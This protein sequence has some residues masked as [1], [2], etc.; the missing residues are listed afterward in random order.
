MS[1][2][3]EVRPADSVADSRGKALLEE[4]HVSGVDSVRCIQTARGYILGGDRLDR[5][6]AQAAVVALLRDPVCEIASFTGDEPAPE[7]AHR[8][9]VLRKPGVMDPVAHTVLETLHHLGFEDI[10]WVRTFSRYFIHGLDADGSG[11]LARRVLANAVI[12]D[13]YVD[14]PDFPTDFA[15]PP[16][17]FERRE[18]ALRESSVAELLDI[19]GRN[20]LALDEAEMRTVQAHFRDLGRNP[21][22]VE[23]E[24]IAQ[25][26][27]EHCKHKTFRGVIDFDGEK[28]DNLLK[29]TIVRATTE[30]DRDWCVSVFHD[31]AG[32]IRFDDEH[33]VCFKVETHNHPSAIEPYGGAGTGIG[34]VIRDVLGTGLGARPIA[35]TDV[36]CVGPLDLE[37]DKVPRGALHPRR[38]LRGVVAGVR[39]YGNRMG[40]PTVS[41]AV[42]FGDRYI[43]NPLVF[44]GSVGILPRDKAFKAARTGDAIVVLG[45]RTGRDGIHGATFSSIELSSESE[46]VSSGAVQ[47]GDPITEK[48][49]LDALLIARDQDLYTSITDCG[50]GGLSSAVCEM[51]EELGAEVHLDRVPLKYAGLTYAEIWISEAQERM[52]VSVPPENVDRLLS[53]FRAEDVEATVIGT[54]TDDRRLHLFYR[55]ESVADLE[56]SFLHDGLPEF[57]RPARWTLPASSPAPR[58]PGRP[59][60]EHL[61]ALLARP[62]IASKEWIIRQYDHEVQAASVLKPLQGATHDGPGDAAVIAPVLGSTVGLAIGCGI[63]P[64]TGDLDPG[65]M[66]RLCIDEALRNVVAVGGDP[67]HTAILD[68]FAWG[69]PERPE[70][71]GALVLASRGCYEAAVAYGTPFIS[72]KDSLNNEFRTEDGES[73]SIPPTLLISALARVPDIRRCLSFELKEPGRH[74]LLIGKTQAAL[75]GSHIHASLGV[76][77]GSVPRVDLDLGPRILRRV[78]DVIRRGLAAACHDVSDGG[79]GVALAEMAF[80]GGVGAR[81]VLANVPTD[82]ELDDWTALFGESPSRF[83]IE[84]RREDA[85]VVA[86]MLEDLPYICL[87]TTGGENL[88][89][90]GRD[91]QTIIDEPLPPL[92]AAWQSGLAIMEVHRQ[93]ES[94]S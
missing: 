80:S 83:L 3:I 48:K 49:L 63:D 9:D 14:R 32:I 93:G 7:A 35:S 22:D 54:F 15:I 42:C 39:D 40:I 62:D 19:S 75:A 31:N 21:T 17:P 64:R 94:G 25:T 2:K 77:G 70:A 38:V 20:V 82:D 92:K 78:A 46:T 33:D 66:A 86:Q 85:Q 12:E 11:E 18:V 1:W 56:M 72:G 59:T 47:I 10:D 44:C 73:V 88:V 23:L 13:V 24:T 41:G 71:L 76:S 29:Q 74:L 5:D 30:L 89:I 8:I 43:G 65:E 60:G 26:W 57:H 16:V 68:N 37:I 87:G 81:V 90:T 79:L 28:I 69:S 6:R 34:G 53:V 50:A 52:V 27:S 61:K 55:D 4:A 84:V 67:D 36:F 45:G 58:I 51:G 91:G